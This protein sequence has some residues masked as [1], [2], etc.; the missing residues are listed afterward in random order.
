MEVGLGCVCLSDLAIDEFSRCLQWL[1]FNMWPGGGASSH[2]GVCVCVCVC[3]RVC[4]RACVCES[5]ECV[6]L[7]CDMC[8][9][10]CIFVVQ[11]CQRF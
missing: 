6:F 10:V 9:C 2:C 7:L 1:W 8:V 5:M 4:M 11:Q 3:V